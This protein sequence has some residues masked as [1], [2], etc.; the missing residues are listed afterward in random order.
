MSKVALETAS[1]QA[2]RNAGYFRM[3]E[4]HERMRKQT[5][6][7]EA[8]EKG[9]RRKGEERDREASSELS[10]EYMFGSPGIS[11]LLHFMYTS[12]LPILPT[13]SQRPE[14]SAH[15]CLSGLLNKN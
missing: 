8:K 1:D 11:L 3:K 7:E 14:V 13:R 10:K 5:T 6:N 12:I 2:D 15:L 4:N 9:R